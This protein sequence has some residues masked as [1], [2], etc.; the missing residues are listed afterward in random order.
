MAVETEASAAAGVPIWSE[1]SSGR[2]VQELAAD[3][4]QATL[5]PRVAGVPR[6]E[7]AAAADV[8]AT[9]RQEPT[10]AA[11]VPVTP[12]KE[13]PAAADVPPRPRVTAQRLAS[14]VKSRRRRCPVTPRCST[15]GSDR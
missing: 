5:R 15:G 6:Q 8:P 13:P 14:R 2:P 12:R 11:D 9:P 4:T 10:A 3:E 1:S 7:P